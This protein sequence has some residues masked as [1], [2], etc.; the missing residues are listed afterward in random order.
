MG[1]VKRKSNLDGYWAK[2]TEEEKKELRKKQNE[3]A[4]A[5]RDAKKSKIEEAKRKAEEFLP[6]Q[7]ANNI[8]AAEDA[9][10]VPDQA[11]L[12]TIIELMH[13]GMDP[14]D[15]KRK[16]GA[17]DK[18]WEKYSKV[19]F[20]SIDPNIQDVALALYTAKLEAKNS[21]T[22]MFLT[23]EKEIKIHKRNEKIKNK[24]S[25]VLW[26]RKLKPTIPN[27]LLAQLAKA[28]QDKLNAENDYA[29]L[30][31]LIGTH[32]KKNSAPTITIK[33]TIPRPGVDPEV[34]SVTEVKRGLTLEEAMAELKNG[35]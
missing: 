26:E 24:N 16:I 19:L 14:G 29:K 27:Y 7:M 35:S 17:S 31:Q 6:I 8:L 20:H 28:T 32:D 33:T 3:K 22:R 21:A 1:D 13:K 15:I 2:F 5:T 12:N 23:I 34:Q 11:T 4:K 30:L 10:W 18:A 25:S 9:N